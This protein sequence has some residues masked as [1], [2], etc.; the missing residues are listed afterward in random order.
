MRIFFNFLNNQNVT[1]TDV[2]KV[3]V[4][5]LYPLM[6]M[7][8]AFD[9]VI[10]PFNLS[11]TYDIFSNIKAIIPEIQQRNITLATTCNILDYN[12]NIIYPYDNELYSNIIVLQQYNVYSNVAIVDASDS[13]IQYPI[14]F[15]N[16]YPFTK[17]ETS[18]LTRF[19]EY[20]HPVPIINKHLQA[21]FVFEVVTM[22]P[23]KTE[24]QITKK[25]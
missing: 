17:K 5:S 2:F 24:L 16:D 1:V 3:N 10:K 13:S 25:K 12:G 18:T 11:N 6:D 7:A 14:L 8:Y 15:N 4:D 22:V 21:T 20:R 19:F 23:D 9:A